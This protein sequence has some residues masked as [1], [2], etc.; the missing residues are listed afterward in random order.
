MFGPQFF[1]VQ[2]FG[3][4]YFPPA[5]EIVVDLLDPEGDRGTET[6]PGYEDRISDRR[7]RIQE[8]DD[9]LLNFIADL[10]TKGMLE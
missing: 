10:V 9:A 5:G 3:P 6:P 7:R 1:G 4:Q 2:H 8:E